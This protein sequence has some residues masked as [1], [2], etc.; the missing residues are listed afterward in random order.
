M[1]FQIKSK[2]EDFVVEEVLWEWVPSWKWDFLYVFFE[3]ENLTTMDIV[4]DLTKNFHL[5]RDEV[6]IA[7]L[8]DKAWIT[9]QWISISQRSLSRI[10]WEEK[11]IQT[12]WEKVR[13]LE[14]TYNEFWL[15][16]A[17]NLWN[18][19]EIRLR[20]RQN[21][22]KEIKNQIENNV[23]KIIEKWFPNCFG[24]Q[25]FGKWKKNFYEAKDH[26]KQLAKEFNEKWKLKE[27]DLPYHLRFLLQAYPS[28]Y[29]NEYVLNRWEK[30]LFLLQWDI[31]VDR[32]NSNWVKTTVYDSQKIYKFDYQKL[33]KEKSE[34]NFF[35]PDISDKWND[36]NSD[37]RFPTGPMLWWNLLLPSEWSKARVR[38]N[39]LL[40]LAEFDEWMQQV[41][42]IYNLWWV[43]R[44]LFIK[45]P[46]LKFE[47]DNDDIKLQFFLPT[48]S[49]ATTL[50]SFI[51]QWIDHLT[52]KDNSL[53]IPRIS[54]K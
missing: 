44:V 31:L 50:V 26:L 5:Q 1:L 20:A 15:K 19:F 23:Q 12:I 36:F 10:W 4:D 2:P 29:F 48:W 41:C 17:S 45:V 32:F 51:L 22:S 47:W 9:R 40:E 7:W 27:S 16:V 34:L 3:K 21:V 8:K 37:K 38:D 49:Y 42:K 25:R 11:F 13:I 52:L 18:K 43:R 24:M 14:K 28:M 33:K 30:W 6:W 54:A 53:L 39:Q 46:N 35:E